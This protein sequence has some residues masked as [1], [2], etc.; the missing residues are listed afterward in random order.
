MTTY[1]LTYF[2]FDGGRGEPVRIAL[3]AAGIDFEDHRIS[4]EQ[5]MAA[6]NDMRFHCVPVLEVDGVAVTHSTGMLRYA[7]RLGGLYPDDPLQALYC[8]EAMGAI[9][10][11]LHRMGP[12]FS[13]Q[14]E[15]LKKAREELVE[16]WISV[17][18]RGL[19]DLLARGG[20]AYFADNRLTVADLKVASMVLSLQSGQMD[21]IPTDLVERLAPA[22]AEHAKQVMADPKVAAWYATRVQ[23]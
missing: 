2:D 19:Q 22:L 17:F 4:F 20:G 14:G 11:L 6:R 8:D 12:T 5:F 13:M 9:E 15:E 7:G 3:H 23:T 18:V 21:H 16:G 10:D 1:K